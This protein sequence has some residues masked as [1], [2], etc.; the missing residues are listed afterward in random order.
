MTD[1]TPTRHDNPFFDK[2]ITPVNESTMSKFSDIIGEIESVTRNI[3]ER[4]REA[5]RDFEVTSV[6]ISTPEKIDMED[7]INHLIMSWCSIYDNYLLKDM[8]IKE[9]FK[10]HSHTIET[11]HITANDFEMDNGYYKYYING[12]VLTFKPI[13]DRWTKRSNE[14]EYFEEIDISKYDSFSVRYTEPFVVDNLN[15]M[16]DDNSYSNWEAGVS[17]SYPNP[18]KFSN[19]SPK[20]E[21]I[22]EVILNIGMSDNVREVIDSINIGIYTSPT[23]L[24]IVEILEG[25]REAALIKYGYNH[26]T[27]IDAIINKFNLDYVHIPQSGKIILSSSEIPI[28]KNRF[29]KEFPEKQHLTDE[30]RRR[31]LNQVGLPENR[32]SAYLDNKP[33]E[34]LIKEKELLSKMKNERKLTTREIQ[35]FKFSRMHS[36]LTSDDIIDLVRE[37]G[38]KRS[39][40]RREG[41]GEI[42]DSILD[43]RSFTY[44]YGPERYNQT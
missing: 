24:S 21:K 22:Q 28:D 27:V 16:L 41:Y 37:G 5:Y 33:V 17:Y 8:P 13:D 6:E 4:Q 29:T 1:I 35:S 15:R 9:A 18:R 25:W 36:D 12:E 26:P 31:I 7:E 3:W 42:A 19:K 14:T 40:L 43:K 39:K 32:I 23:V 20:D 11:N 44:Q 30:E 10:S 2:A 34:H 38:R